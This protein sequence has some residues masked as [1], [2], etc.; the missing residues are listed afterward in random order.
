LNYGSQLTERQSYFK[1]PTQ[2]PNFDGLA[3]LYSAGRAKIQDGNVLIYH[4]IFL[5]SKQNFVLNL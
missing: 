1:L 5:S 3:K 4:Y 2:S